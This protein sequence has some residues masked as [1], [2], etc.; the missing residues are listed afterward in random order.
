MTQF[1]PTQTKGNR[2]SSSLEITRSSS[3]SSSSDSLAAKTSTTAEKKLR[4]R[5]VTVEPNSSKI[6]AALSSQ[7]QPGPSSSEPSGVMTRS[8]KRKREEKGNPGENESDKKIKLESKTPVNEGGEAG[9]IS[10]LIAEAEIQFKFHPF[11]EAILAEIC[12]V[13]PSVV[14]N[15]EFTYGG[16]YIVSSKEET[17]KQHAID[18]ALE[19]FFSQKDLFATLDMRQLGGGVLGL[20]KRRLKIM[21]KGKEF[22]KA[23]KPA[24]NQIHV[25]NYIRQIAYNRNFNADPMKYIEYWIQ[26]RGS[27]APQFPLDDALAFFKQIKE[28]DERIRKS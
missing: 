10:K 21:E 6:P 28:S 13:L 14:E 19:S 26:N 22:V 17:Q 16:S 18:D 3:S 23:I 5:K 27:K 15:N 9:S 1:L 25:L 11:K 4:G 12:T 2:M 24:E 7:K 8:Q 20:E